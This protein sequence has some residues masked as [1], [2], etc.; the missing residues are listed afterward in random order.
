MLQERMEDASSQRE[1]MLLDPSQNA[2]SNFK[3][4]KQIFNDGPDPSMKIMF[5][6]PSTGWIR[7]E[8]HTA[9]SQLIIPC[10]WTNSVSSPIGFDVASARNHVVEHALRD[11]HDWILF[12][13]HDVILPPD[14]LVKMRGHMLLAR[15]PIVGGLYYAKSSRP[16]PLIYRGR[17]N[18]PYYDWDPGDQVWVDGMGM[19]C[20]MIHTSLFRAMSP[21]WFESP[22]RYTFDKEKGC[23]IHEAGTED[24]FFLSRVIDENIIEKTGI[25]WDIEDPKNPFIMDTSLYCGHID[26]ATG[27]VY[28]ECRPESDW[29]DIHLKVRER[30]QRKRAEAAAAA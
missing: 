18:G 6:I 22:R 13:D 27:K 25:K 1:A 3:T 16:E 8:F 24:L 29:K 7:F 21:P 11:G 4:V 19:G 9:M 10:N 5:G 2:T 28:P 26:H 15:S 12:V 17:G 23:Y 20:T 30:L 14:T